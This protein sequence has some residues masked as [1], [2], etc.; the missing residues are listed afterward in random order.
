MF[1][2]SRFNGLVIIFLFAFHTS[3][4]KKESSYSSAR[5][6]G[7]EASFAYANSFREVNLSASEFLGDF[8]LNIEV[9]S[10]PADETTDSFEFYMCLK[11][12]SDQCQP[13]HD[14]PQF[15]DGLYERDGYDYPLAPEGE[16]EVFVRAC[17]NSLEKRICGV[18]QIFSYT[19]P[20]SLD[21]ETSELV[22]ASYIASTTLDD[23][24]TAVEDISGVSFEEDE[25]PTDSILNEL[26]ADVS[27]ANEIADT[28]DDSEISEETVSDSNSDSNEIADTDDDSEISE[29]T[30]SDSNSDSNETVETDDDSE[31][32]EETV[33]DSNSASNEIADTDDDSEISEE[34]VSDSNSDLNEIAD[35][36]DS[37]ISEETVSDSNSA[38]NE[39]AD[40]DGSEISEET[41]SDSNETADTDG[42]NFDPTF[43]EEE[44]AIIVGVSAVS[45]AAIP[46]IVVYASKKKKNKLE[47]AAAVAAE[48]AYNKN[49][50]ENL[51]NERKKMLVELFQLKNGEIPVDPTSPKDNKKIEDIKK[52][53][54]KNNTDIQSGI[55][56]ELEWE[57]NRKQIGSLQEIIDLQNKPNKI[58][59]MNYKIKKYLHTVLYEIDF[60][61][62][63]ITKKI[64]EID[65]FSSGKT[66]EEKA[67][68]KND[69]LLLES[70]IEI[71][72]KMKSDR[73]SEKTN[74]LKLAAGEK[75]GELEIQK[76]KELKKIALREK[77][78]VLAGVTTTDKFVEFKNAMKELLGLENNIFNQDVT[79]QEKLR[80]NDPSTEE[81]KN[82]INYDEIN[83]KKL[84]GQLE[85]WKNPLGTIDHRI[86]DMKF[87]ALTSTK[88]SSLAN[89]LEKYAEDFKYL[90]ELRKKID[91]A[92]TLKELES[93]E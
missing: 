27:D 64:G 18:W 46:L 70:K 86:S 91:L 40:T 52:E 76:M 73:I 30:V 5:A 50:L 31:I 75:V 56:E 79:V 84:S 6:I 90:Y 38:S 28:D 65:N 39:T 7:A 68:A 69:N 77:A 80:T 15:V 78:N 59:D 82:L 71:L 35:T 37:V 16:N 29:E 93:L 83:Y 8:V 3:C 41:V 87:L 55:A 89:F 25:D 12:D 14:A 63:L 10:Y 47:L 58:N 53:L 23:M 62:G 19:Q 36:N 34:A 13:S 72:E 66:E 1:F 32:S 26:L 17:N 42:F 88:K 45:I 92:L 21:Q 4:N 57:D 22:D 51:V 33:S 67:K 61:E 54:E 49:K 24:I 2:Y 74:I 48:V 44:I 20:A 60:L 85:R 9:I 81:F 11:G 43:D